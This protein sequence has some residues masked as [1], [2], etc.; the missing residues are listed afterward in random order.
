MNL[1]VFGSVIDDVASTS[2]VTRSMLPKMLWTEEDPH[3]NQALLQRSKKPH[4][5]R[6]MIAPRIA[7]MKPALSPALYH[8]TA[9]PRYVATK[10]PAMPSRVVKMNPEA[11]TVFQGE[12]ISRSPLPQTQ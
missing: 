9:W 1:L 6:T 11:R 8:P 2:P 3:R 7:P 10:A 5:T 12:L 4:T